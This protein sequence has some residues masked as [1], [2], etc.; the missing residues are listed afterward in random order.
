MKGLKWVW[1]VLKRVGMCL[2]YVLTALF[3]H[4]MEQQPDTTP[5]TGTPR[6]LDLMKVKVPRI[7]EVWFKGC[8]SGMYFVWV[9]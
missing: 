6:K 8:H 7:R 3:E 1:K 2:I 9:L 5:H 4:E